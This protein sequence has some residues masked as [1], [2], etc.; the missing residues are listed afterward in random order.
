[1]KR[2]KCPRL[3]VR[4]SANKSHPRTAI[5]C[6]STVLDQEIEM[7]IIAENDLMNIVHAVPTSYD[8]FAKISIIL[9]VY[10]GFDRIFEFTHNQMTS[11]SITSVIKTKQETISHVIMKRTPCDPI[12]ITY[13]SKDGE[14]HI[15]KII[16]VFGDKTDFVFISDV[17]LDEYKQTINSF[18]MNNSLDDK[19][20]SEFI[21]NLGMRYNSRGQ[22]Y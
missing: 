19:L 5:V 11:V 1:M 16:F 7:S 4:I 21:V 10:Y 6:E 14:T 12:K 2:S 8:A 22:L 15:Y 17:T 3:I 9:D 18:I 13:I 20:K